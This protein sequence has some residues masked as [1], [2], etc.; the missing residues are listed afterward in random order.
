M[1]K[2]IPT[3]D[4]GLRGRRRFAGAAFAPTSGVAHRVPPASPDVASNNRS[5]FGGQILLLVSGLT[6]GV[7]VISALGLWTGLAATRLGM[8]NQGAFYL[9]VTGVYLLAT[10]L[11]AAWK[12]R[13]LN[14]LDQTPWDARLMVYAN[15]VVGGS[16]ILILGMAVLAIVAIVVA[17]A[18]FGALLLSGTGG[19]PE[20]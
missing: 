19:Q 10:T 3:N 6:G 8:D 20:D 7:A 4:A 13:L 16:I 15:L 17:L 11:Y 5:L 12:T 2:P 18:W 9:L 1:A 14:N